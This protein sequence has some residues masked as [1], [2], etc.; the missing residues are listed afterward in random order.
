MR[1]RRTFCRL[2]QLVD[3]ER[4]VAIDADLAGG[5]KTTFVCDPI[6]RR[7][8]DSGEVSL[9]H[10]RDVHC[11][12]ESRRFANLVVAGRLRRR[13]GDGTTWF[14]DAVG[15]IAADVRSNNFPANHEL[16]RRLDY[17]ADDPQ[18]SGS[19]LRTT[20][21]KI[22]LL[23]QNDRLQRLRGLALVANKTGRG[24]GPVSDWK[25]VFE[26]KIIAH[27]N[28]ALENGKPVAA[29]APPRQHRRRKLAQQLRPDPLQHDK[30]GK[31]ELA[32]GIDADGSF[33]KTA[34]GLPLRTISDTPNLT[35]TLL[36]RPNKNTL[37]VFQDDGAVVEQYRVS[38]LEQMIAFDCGDFE[39]K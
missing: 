29:S 3:G 28:F 23:E 18:P 33:L 5:K 9:L 36:A 21:E 30:P 27:Q 37:D 4:R 39:L 19:R 17:V 26:K 22:F 14:V 12:R 35:R 34:D 10:C 11:D 15:G 16:L 7:R 20:E 31:A 6:D 2:W 24:E 32:V 1:T 25:I 38:N 13:A 8:S